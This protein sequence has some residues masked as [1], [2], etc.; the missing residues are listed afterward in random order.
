MNRAAI[1]ACAS[2]LCLSPTAPGQA[3][4]TTSLERQV[5]AQRLERNTSPAP[6]IGGG[7][8]GKL[9]KPVLL[10]EEQL[11]AAK[12][13]RRWTVVPSYSWSFFNK[14]RQSWY[15]E[16]LQILYRVNDKLFVGAE[17]DLLQ[18]PPAGNDELYSVLASWY[19]WR[20]LELHGK[21][22]ICPDPEFSPT[23]IYSGGLEW[24]VAP[25]LALLLDYQQLNFGT[26]GA[27]GP[28]SIEQA[29][30]GLTYWFTDDVSL[31]LRYARGY[32]FN[33]FGYNYYSASFS[34]SNLPGGGR[35]VASFAYGTD[36]DLDFGTNESSLSNAYIG[37][38]YYTQP[39]T[40]DLSV[41]AGLQYVY[42]MKQN[43]TA[44]LYQQ[45]TPT[46]GLVWK[47]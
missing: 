45:L 40:K 16:D 24:Q 8:A 36:P 13:A 35:V 9:S 10:G 17:I 12:A 20:F 37:S 11:A 39:I 27:V 31:T 3:V 42:R 23:Q 2:L 32:A 46:V 41:F 38:L 28:G 33:D 7:R 22:T 14:G 25:R 5:I 6:A 19:P 47:F 1:L 26:S 21:L 29:K 44:E 15:E 43:S 30:V 34:V 4:A 18:R